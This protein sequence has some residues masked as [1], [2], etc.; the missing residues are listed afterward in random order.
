M[1]ETVLEREQTITKRA[2]S[3][4]EVHPKL[5]FLHT[6]SPT[7]LQQKQPIDAAFYRHTNAMQEVWKVLRSGEI[8]RVYAV[9]L[10]SH[11]FCSGALAG[12]SCVSELGA[13]LLELA[14]WAIGSPDILDAKGYLYADGLP[15]SSGVSDTNDYGLATL[16]L[17][18]NT[19]LQLCCSWNLTPEQEP[20][21]S[22][23][24]YGING[25]V[26][27]KSMAGKPGQFMAERY[28]GLTTE[29]LY[30][31]TISTDVSLDASNLSYDA[32]NSTEEEVGRLTDL[33]EK[34]FRK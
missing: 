21:V 11:T 31:P 10:I 33:L 3:F 23:T 2:A 14:L 29:I 5:S 24:F 8:G 19:S 17:T 16:E 20:M 18:G 32:L 34:I 9:E 26:A 7:S 15:C 22:A 30:S 28:K 12:R 6:S 27:F 1:Q 13:P 25:G 4:K